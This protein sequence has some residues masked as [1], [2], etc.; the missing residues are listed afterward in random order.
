MKTLSLI[1]MLA[2]PLL[3]HAK[4]FAIATVLGATITLSDTPCKL[5]FLDGAL[6]A[7]W[8]EGGKAYTGCWSVN[9]LGIILLWTDDKKM[10]GIPWNAFK[11]VEAL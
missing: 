6:E 4:P 1:L 10:S 8:K 5:P 7:E 3:V 11:K 9:R 2:F